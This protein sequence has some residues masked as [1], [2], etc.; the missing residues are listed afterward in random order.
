MLIGEVARRCGVSA[1]MLRHYD[2]IGLVV[3]TGRTS[4]GYREYS[5]DDI[6]RLF[7]VE[8]LR[9][10]GLSLADIRHAVDRDDF[11]PNSVVAD[12]IAQT[13]QRIDAEQQL[14]DRLERVERFAPG[15]WEDVVM[16]VTSLRALGSDSAAR[17]QQVVLSATPDAAIPIE[18]LVEAVLAENDPY[19]AGALQW[20]LSRTGAEAVPGLAAAL[21]DPDPAVR[22][23]AVAALAEVRDGAATEALQRAL[24]DADTGIR[25]QVALVVGARGVTEAQEV[26][27]DMV[28]AGHHDVAAA[29]VLGILVRDTGADVTTELCGHLQPAAAQEVRLRV[30]QALAELPDDAALT[31]LARLVNDPDA[32]IAATA[33]AILR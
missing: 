9:T 33:A 24:T 4:G 12:L 11:D 6:R 30:T 19:V 16:V 8:S 32:T 21:D 22:R 13:R 26:L 25:E 7:Q 10:L 5:A 18:E 14:L 1:R 15:A 29:E 20:S 27:V 23:R 31:A 3:P 17:R 2:R 28:V